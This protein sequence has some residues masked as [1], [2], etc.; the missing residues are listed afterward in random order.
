MKNRRSGRILTELYSHAVTA[1]DPYQLVL[2][3]ANYQDPVLSIPG[4]GKMLHY[5]LSGYQQV[6]LIAVGKGAAR[7]ALAF[8]ELLG[9]RLTSGLAIVKPGHSERLTTVE[10]MEAG[11]PIPN[12]NSLRAAYRIARTAREADEKTLVINCI[13]G[14][15]SALAVY[16]LEWTVGDTITSITLPELQQVFELLLGSGATVHEMNCCRKHLSGIKGGRLARFLYPATSIN[17]YLSDVIGDQFDVIASGLLVPDNT[18]FMDVQQILNKY[19]LF[20]KLPA[21][22]Q[23]LV[24]DGISGL[25]EETPSSGHYCFSKSVNILL[26][27]NRT[28]LDAVQK[29]AAQLKLDTL[30]LNARL[31]GEAKEIGKFL[32][33]TAMT[34]HEQVQQNG[35]PLLVLCG[36][37]A[38][39]TLHGSGKGGR[40]QETA[41]SFLHELLSAETA[42]RNFSLLSAST[43]GNDGPTDVAGGMVFSSMRDLI[44]HENLSS[45]QALLQNDSYHFLDGIDGLFRTGPTNTNVCDLHMLLIEP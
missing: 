41:L 17:F 12:E 29:R 2:E 27:N 33:G 15:G 34:L 22:V 40:C 18:T 21:T 1:V 20:E 11:H 44:L 45:E 28:A 25:V 4:P 32:F 36:G 43:D 6:L 23:Q 16:P 13:S 24:S 38:T 10:I 9:A 30:L 39:V 14:G 5:D 31:S 19:G 26:A 7:M 37:E 35:R 3:K 8:E 42:S